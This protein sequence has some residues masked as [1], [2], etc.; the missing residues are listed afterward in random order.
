VTTF[1][2]HPSYYYPLKPRITFKSLDGTDTYF[3]FNGHGSPKDIN[4]I[5]ADMSYAMGETGDFNIVVED[6]ANVI[7][8]DHL[9]NTKVYLELGKTQSTLQHFLIGFADIMDINEPRTNYQEYRISGFGSAIQAQEILLLI[10]QASKKNDGNF[11]VK[12]LF[13]R[14]QQER[15]FRPL[16]RNAIEELNGWQLNISSKLSTK[17]P[18]INEVF[19]TQWDFYDRL[20]AL[21]G[22]DWYIDFTGGIETLTAKNPSK[23]HSGKIV[24]TGD[25]KSPSDKADNVSYI[26]EA[27]SIVDDSSSSAGVKTRLYTT[28]VIEQEVVSESLTNK[29]SS[30]LNERFIAQQINLLNDERRI[31]DLKFRLRKIG[32]PDSPKGRINGFVILDNDDKPTGKVL[33]TFNID[34]SQIEDDSDEITVN[35]IDIKS[36]FLEGGGKIWIGF[37]DRSGLKGNVE[38][39]EKNTIAWHHD[40]SVNT[41]HTAGTYS[42]TAVATENDRD[43]PAGADWKVSTTGPVYTYSV[44]STIRRLLA[45]SNQTAIKRLRNKESFV[46]TSFLKDPISVNKFL[47]LNLNVMSKTRRTI[48]GLKVTVPNNFIFKP[49][50]YAT[51]RD[52]QSTVD[53]DLQIARVSYIISALPGDP[54]LGTYEA[55]ITLNG[56]YNP[57]V[58][59]CTC[60]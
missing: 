51:F 21:E 57:L 27:F 7:A 37:T 2:S 38:N 44:M 40:N 8:R 13:E 43:D 20:A 6:T 49:F 56:A 26:T 45:R 34:I 33:G 59:G 36:R 47:A 42:A 46:D 4:V 1:T 15:K 28:T 55:E 19:T 60:E 18:V 53:Q 41:A 25:L 31:T 24:K 3:T 12:K 9:H 48:N 35:D 11:T 30:T 23:N 32:E 10:R 29:G 5:Y 16:N 54:Q 58:G 17:F 52:G 39:D 14:C 22:A 50:Q